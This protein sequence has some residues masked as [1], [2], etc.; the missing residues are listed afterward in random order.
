[1]KTL[2]SQVRY[3]SGNTETKQLVSEFVTFLAWTFYCRAKANAK[4][5]RAKDTVNI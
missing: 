2:V 1:M 4:K 5:L 3:S